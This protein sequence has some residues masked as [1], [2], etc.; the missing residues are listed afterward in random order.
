MNWTDSRGAIEVLFEK[1]LLP[2]HE[3]LKS[4]G[5]IFPHDPD[6]SLNSFYISRKKTRMSREDFEVAA[7]EDAAGF[8]SALHRLWD[9]SSQVDL[10]GTV[11]EHAEAARALAEEAEEQTEEVSPFTYVMF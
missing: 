9:D 8:A 1:T 4:S 3:E 10:T 7:Y 6:S 2:I 11:G 5:T